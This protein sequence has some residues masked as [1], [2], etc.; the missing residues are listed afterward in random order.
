MH[1]TDTITRTSI[2]SP[3]GYIYLRTRPEVYIIY[4][5]P[6]STVNW[7]FNHTNTKRH[8]M[9]LN[10]QNYFLIPLSS[11]VSERFLLRP[12]DSHLAETGITPDTLREGEF[13]ITSQ[14]GS[15]VVDCRLHSYERLCLEKEGLSE[16]KSD[17]RNLFRRLR[18]LLK[19]TKYKTLPLTL[20]L[21]TYL[22]SYRFMQ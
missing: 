21:C 19:I 17:F 13:I 2:Y 20:N 12:P 22:Q 14:L 11:W 9:F 7:T 5:S 16:S 10:C 3:I 15:D 1:F 4:D 18:N 6:G 8:G